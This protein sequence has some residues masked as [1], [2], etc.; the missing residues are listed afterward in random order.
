[1][2]NIAI[3]DSDYV[4]LRETEFLVEKF[5][6]GYGPEYTVYECDSFK[7]LKELLRDNV[8]GLLIFD[9][10]II[11]N[12]INAADYISNLNERRFGPDIIIMSEYKNQW[13]DGFEMGALEYLIKPYEP[14]MLRQAVLYSAKRHMHLDFDTM[15]KD[16]YGRHYYVNG[17]DIIY[18]E[19]VNKDLFINIIGGKV[20]HGRRTSTDIRICE[21]PPFVRCHNSFF[22][23]MD[24]VAQ[25]CR[26]SI[27]LTN[28]VNIPISKLKYNEFVKAYKNYE[29]K[30]VAA[31]K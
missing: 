20:I 22:V 21:K 9:S 23:N 14:E 29:T 3:C 7:R 11:D 28:G 26:Y 15:I 5:L 16:I 10:K 18:A 31:A 25:F 13:S 12:N 1:M 27:K 6:N 30:C 4:C 17:R 8:F 24:Y 19:I 2:Y